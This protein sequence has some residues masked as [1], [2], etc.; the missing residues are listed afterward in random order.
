[1]RVVHVVTSTGIG[2]AQVMLHRYLRHLG[3]E[4]RDHVVV[5]LMPGGR[6]GEL[7][8]DLGVEVHDVGLA[9]IGSLAPGLARLRKLVADLAPDVVHGWMYHGCLAASLAVAGRAQPPLI[10]GIHHSLADPSTESRALRAILWTMPTLARRVS[11]ITYCGGTIALQHEQVGF[12]RKL[13]EIIANGI[14]TESFV[15]DGTAKRHLISALG[16]PEGRQVIGTAI[17]YHPMKDPGTL[18]RAAERLVDEGRDIQVLFLG[19]GHAGGPTEALAR[20]SRIFDRVSLMPAQ[21]DIRKIVAGFDVFA[22]SSA[23]GEAFPLA[24]GEAM[25]CGVPVACT[26]VG[27]LDWLTGE[28]DKLTEPRD[29]RALAERIGEILDQPP[30]AREAMGL[31]YRQRILG[32]FGM[33]AYASAHDAL[34]RRACGQVPAVA[35]E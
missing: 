1:M 27:D 17:R 8:S 5:S 9:S 13:S 10:W 16:I 25:S 31:A 11:A 4:A 26:H 32:N 18:I 28:P 24:V 7:I 33:D 20:N 30:A 22:L 19:E 15:P 12:P 34:Y 23:W 21:S 35:A 2:G 14:D 3:P 6:I 29:D